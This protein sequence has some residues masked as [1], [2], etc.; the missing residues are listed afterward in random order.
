MA[1][2]KYKCFKDLAAAEKPGEDYEIE[3][4]LQNHSYTVVIAPHG[5]TIEP[6]TD[7]IADAIAG[8]DFSFYCFRAL[9]KNSGLHIKSPLFD[10]PNCEN[11]V[12][13]HQ[14][15]VSIHGWG[16]GGERLCIGGRDAELIAALKKELVAKGIQVE[17]AKDSLA[18]TDTKNITNRGATGC[19]VQFELT[20][21]FRKNAVLVEKF[22][23]AVR[24]VLLDVMH[25]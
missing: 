5:G 15:V 7:K 24:A 3:S 17:D 4:R 19:G 21:G 14:Q 10:E 1:D 23:A 6:S 22:T 16:E 13:A 25:G 9:K 11:L 8:E 12:S 2:D 20:R 18:G